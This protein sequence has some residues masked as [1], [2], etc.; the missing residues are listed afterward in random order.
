MEA[1]TLGTSKSLVIADELVE[2]LADLRHTETDDHLH[3]LAVLGDAHG[4]DGLEVLVLGHLG[5]VL[6]VH[7][8][9][10]DAVG[11][12][13]DIVHATQEVKDVRGKNHLLVARVDVGCG[14][15]GLV[16]ALGADR[17]R[18][19]MCLAELLLGAE[20][21]LLVFL[22]ARSLEVELQ[23]K[24]TEDKEVDGRKGEA[25]GNGHQVRE[26]MRGGKRYEVERRHLDES[27][28]EHAHDAD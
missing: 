1:Y 19:P 23:N 8:Q 10:C 18:H 28:R 12:V 27:A 5:L 6:H 11:D 26:A 16:G 7:A 14:R 25:D 4:A 17:L 9:A 2:A 15:A 13:H 20:L 24:E 21:Y 22:T 3:C